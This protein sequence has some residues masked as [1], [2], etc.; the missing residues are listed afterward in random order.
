VRLKQIPDRYYHS[1]IPHIFVNGASAA[2]EF[3][4][5][6]LGATEIFRISQPNGQ[7]VHA[8]IKIGDSIIM[9]GD[10]EGIFCAPQSIGGS[11]VGLHVYIDNLDAQFTQAVN[12]GAKEIQ[13]VQDMFYGDRMAMLEDPFGHIWVLLTHQEDLTLEEIKRRGEAMLQAG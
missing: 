11:T 2:I 10:A 3:Y 12:V 4:K 9:L 13:P 8:E 6:A 1:V 5:Q 7:I